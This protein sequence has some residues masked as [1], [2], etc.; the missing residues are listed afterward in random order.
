MILRKNRHP[1]FEF[2]KKVKKIFFE[3]KGV[4]FI[5]R[6]L[7]SSLKIVKILPWTYKK[8]PWNEKL[9]RFIGYQNLRQ[10]T[11][12]LI[13]LWWCQCLFVCLICWAVSF[14]MLSSLIKWNVSIYYILY[15]SNLITNI[16]TVLFRLP[17]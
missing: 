16:C 11:G 2:L 14:W 1:S 9:N 4:I 12:N 15:L 10:Q 8:L 7:V 6:V 13:S 3:G 5:G 17:I